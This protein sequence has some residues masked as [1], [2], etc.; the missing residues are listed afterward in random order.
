MRPFCIS[1]IHFHC[2]TRRQ[3]TSSGHTRSKPLTAGR[4]W[5]SDDAETRGVVRSLADEYLRRARLLSP[6]M[7]LE[8]GPYIL[9]YT[10]GFQGG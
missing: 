9:A 10:R 7:F 5:A 6:D 4:Q 3:R 2:T 8:A 1:G